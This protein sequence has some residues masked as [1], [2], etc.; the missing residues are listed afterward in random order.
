MTKQNPF[1]Q[2]HVEESAYA[3][4]DGLLDQLH[5]PP[6][7]V[8]F[9]RKHKKRIW[10]TSVFVAV[11]VTVISLYGSYT[12][13]RHNKA[14]DA[15]Y[16]ALE[17]LPDERQQKFE[18][19]RSKY[20]STAAGT[21]SAVELA[22]MSAEGD[23]IDASIEQLSALKASTSADNPLLPLVLNKLALLYEQDSDLEKAVTTYKE[24]AVLTGFEQDANFN[25]GRLYE[26]MEKQDQAVVYYEKY[27]ANSQSDDAGQTMGMDPL[28][29]LVQARLNR[30]AK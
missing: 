6:A 15:L 18:E 12:R 26:A 23:N 5:L 17:A 22:L 4:P 27:M 29:T 9:L 2:E 28:T 13:Y 14:A 19:V 3:R 30:L 10:I 25:L 21:W 20:G 24:M 8:S 16:A 11:V 1:N 7:L